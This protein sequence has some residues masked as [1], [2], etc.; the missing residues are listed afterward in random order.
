[1]LEKCLWDCGQPM[2]APETSSESKQPQTKRRAFRKTQTRFGLV[3]FTFTEQWWGVW[4][5]GQRAGRSICSAQA[6][7][8]LV[9]LAQGFGAIHGDFPSLLR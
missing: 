6:T 9:P 7:L 2:G 5:G 4:R 8:C 1:M 3:K